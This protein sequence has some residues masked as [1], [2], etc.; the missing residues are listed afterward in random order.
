MFV[1]LNFMI[2]LGIV[3]HLLKQRYPFTHSFMILCSYNMVR[4][5]KLRIKKTAYITYSTSSLKVGKNS[6]RKSSCVLSKRHITFFLFLNC[7]IAKLLIFACVVF[8]VVPVFY[9]YHSNLG[10][11][12]ITSFLRPL[13]YKSEL[14]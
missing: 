14:V 13:L 9:N 5:F 8:C 1:T 6:L 4:I 3:P 12:G 11:F 10:C 2:K 7:M